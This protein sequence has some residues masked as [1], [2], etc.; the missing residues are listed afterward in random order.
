[1]T[2]SEM[3]LKFNSNTFRW[4]NKKAL[5]P[6]KNSQDFLNPLAK[7]DAFPLNKSE[8]QEIRKENSEEELLMKEI[9]RDKEFLE[10]ELEE[11]EKDLE[12]RNKELILI[13]IKSEIL[14]KMLYE[15]SEKYKKYSDYEF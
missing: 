6:R 3:N 4:E 1:M 14:K 10:S 13:E 9:K 8:L 11:L 15:E 5:H 12:I 2:L 7:S